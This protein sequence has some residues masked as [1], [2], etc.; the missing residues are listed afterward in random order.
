MK[1]AIIIFI[2]LVFLITF[3]Y[4]KLFDINILIIIGV[5]C[6][7]ISVIYI[8]IHIKNKERNTPKPVYITN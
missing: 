1:F 3:K 2:I 4:T 5:F 7:W 8:Q 6:L